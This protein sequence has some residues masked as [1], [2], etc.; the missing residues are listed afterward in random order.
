MS[1]LASDLPEDVSAARDGILKFAE[2]EILPRHAEYQAFFEHTL[3]GSKEEMRNNISDL[4]EIYSYGFHKKNFEIQKNEEQALF[5]EE[6]LKQ[7]QKV[8]ENSNPEELKWRVKNHVGSVTFGKKLELKIIVDW[9]KNCVYMNKDGRVTLY[10][11][12]GKSIWNF[13]NMNDFYK[14]A[15]ADSTKADNQKIMYWPEDDHL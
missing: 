8:I 11:E 9:E 1:A 7:R 3:L 5:W 10:T 14:F 6:K 4:I 12:Y 13:K 15:Y 2:Q